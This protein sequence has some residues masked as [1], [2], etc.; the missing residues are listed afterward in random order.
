[1]KARSV[2]FVVPLLLLGA[3][4]KIQ[5]AVNWFVGEP[6]FETRVVGRNPFRLGPEAQ[7]ITPPEP[8]HIYGEVA[9]LCVVLKT[10]VPL[11]PPD[12]MSQLV[13][14]SLSGGE[15]T[16]SFERNDGR[17]FTLAAADQAWK[18]RHDSSSGDLSA[19]SSCSC[20]AE[21]CASL[22]PTGATITKLKVASSVPLTTLGAYWESADAHDKPENSRR[23]ETGAPNKQFQP[24]N[25]RCA[26]IRG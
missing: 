23:F 19:C 14:E 17:A 21:G 12:V 3:C 11:G 15:I 9:A 26:R 18:R 8:L 5:Q 10:S 2:L 4:G 25:S 16:I 20:S 1:M 24:T 6:G 7:E 22:F 13:A